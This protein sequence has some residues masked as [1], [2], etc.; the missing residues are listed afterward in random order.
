[1][2][3]LLKEVWKIY[4]FKISTVASGSVSL[5]LATALISLLK[6]WFSFPRTTIIL[7]KNETNFYSP[8]DND[9]FHT[10]LFVA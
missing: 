5:L 3:C 9:N 6:I 1:M 2:H 7:H 10:V 4:K 8:V